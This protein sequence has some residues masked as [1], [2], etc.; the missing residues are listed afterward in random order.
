MQ[1][2][3]ASTTN[4]L[5]PIKTIENSA[6]AGPDVSATGLS[7]NAFSSEFTEAMQEAFTES[8]N[9]KP[10]GI[11]VLKDLDVQQLTDLA[12]QM[13]IHLPPELLSD[14]I[15]PKQSILNTLAR[16]INS[17]INGANLVAN[18]NASEILKSV[19][20][21][22][23]RLKDGITENSL[24]G[25]QTNKS[26]LFNRV[27]P[28]EVL[29]QAAIKKEPG[30]ANALT[31]VDSDT[32]HFMKDVDINRELLM[33]SGRQD[34][35]SIKIADQLVSAD[36]PINAI[37][38][39]SNP[40]AQVQPQTSTTTPAM[41]LNRVEVP[42]QQAGW[43]EAVGNRLMMMV[44]DKVQTANIHL[45]PAELGP[46]EVKIRVSQEQATVQF[47]SNNAVVRDAIE[48]AFPRLKEMFSQN[49][50]SLS[51]AN[52]SQQSSQQSNSYSTNENDS[53]TVSDTD[54]LEADE[55]QIE[56]KQINIVDTGLVDHYV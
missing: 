27:A 22:G 36:K 9:S 47:V 13:G 25:S 50:L 26:D 6:L 35:S 2:N 44:N 29:Q 17:S 30:L 3:P 20:V 33:Q 39:I 55:Q 38:S 1:V 41:M 8:G 4:S 28:D 11:A 51:D 21:N 19:I 18:P 56:S 5:S 16:E 54:L 14:S 49:G 42:V 15:D 24:P 37:N 53:Q 40:T 31:V 52:V 7:D 23:N 46:I 34:M 10:L 32:T 12:E 45:N 48:D 43:G